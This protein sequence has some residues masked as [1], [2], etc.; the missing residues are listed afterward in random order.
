MSHLE[1]LKAFLTGN[2]ALSPFPF[3]SCVRHH[4]SPQLVSTTWFIAS[5]VNVDFLKPHWLSARESSA[6]TIWL[7]MILSKIFPTVFNMHNGDD[8]G[9]FVGEL[10]S[11]PE[12]VLHMS[13]NSSG[14][15]LMT[16]LRTTFGILCV[17]P[18]V[19]PGAFLFPTLLQAPRSSSHVT[20]GCLHYQHAPA[21]EKAF[22]LFSQVDE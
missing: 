16:T 1:E 8:D 10:I 2:T 4:L 14:A 7:S 13:R 18:C 11:S 6:A 9:G 22:G 17:H 3:M 5:S 21:A 15:V 20:E 12:H 19:F